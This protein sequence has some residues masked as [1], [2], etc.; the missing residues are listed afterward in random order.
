MVSVPRMA[1]LEYF[2][3]FKSRFYRINFTTIILINGFN[4]DWTLIALGIDEDGTPP[5]AIII[6]DNL[7][8]CFSISSSMI[9]LF[10]C[11]S[12]SLLLI[13]ALIVI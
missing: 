12:I 9:S 2:S 11:R 13:E 8:I 3:F 5:E 10:K 6:F 7:E 4:Q 1:Q